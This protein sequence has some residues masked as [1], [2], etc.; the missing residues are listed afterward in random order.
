MDDERTK[1]L[2]AIDA[3][4]SH[5]GRACEIWNAFGVGSP[6][7]QAQAAS[8]ALDEYLRSLEVL[9]STDL[10][11]LPK[12]HRLSVLSFRERVLAQAATMRQYAADSIDEQLRHARDSV[13]HLQQAAQMLIESKEE[14]DDLLFRVKRDLLFAQGYQRIFSARVA[15]REE[16][17]SKAV[18][19]YKSA[20]SVFLELLNLYEHNDPRLKEVRS[21]IERLDKGPDDDNNVEITEMSGRVIFLRFD[22]EYGVAS[23]E[24]MYRRAAANLYSSAGSRCNIEALLLLTNGA[25]ARDIE[26]K[27]TQSIEFI[28]FAMEAIPT[29]LEF[30]RDL[31][32]AWKIKGERFG[33]PMI[34]TATAFH[35]KCPIAIK[36]LVGKWYV[37]PTLEYDA[38]ACSV[39]GKDALECA[40]T[41]LETMSTASALIITALT[42]ESYR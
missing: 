10:S 25:S 39:C 13:H 17:F 9:D 22:D 1:T 26:A 41:S 21:K 19:S 34:E 29:N 18:S 27:L 31:V 24:S 2:D 20:E 15:G 38:L 11:P 12:P 6:Q 37:S 28:Y 8:A 14:N 5:F 40:R 23:H 32:N 16:E 7:L 35:T 4:D 33:C 30:H 36:E 42:L 3:A